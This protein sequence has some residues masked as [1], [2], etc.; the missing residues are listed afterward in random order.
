MPRPRTPARAAIVAVVVAA[1]LGGVEPDRPVGATIVTQVEPAR[2][3]TPRWVERIRELVGDRPMSVAIGDDGETWFRHRDW[4]LRAPASNEK[5]LLSMA[6]FDRFGTERTIRTSVTTAAPRRRATIHGDVY[7]VGRGDPEVADAQVRELARQVAS[8]GIRRIRGSVVG[9]LGG[10]RRDWWATG[11]RDYFPRWYIARPTALTYRGNRD[12]AGRHVPDPE[13]RAAAALTRRLRKLG[14]RVVDPAAAARPPADTRVLA[15]IASDPLAAIVRRMNVV[16][17]NFSAEVLGKV[18]AA[19]VYGRGTIA[20][21]GRAIAAFVAAHGLAFEAND[22][23]GLSYA[24]RASARGIV[25]LLWVAD[26]HDWGRTLRAG[27][28]RGGRGTLEDRLRDVRVRAKTGTLEAVSALSGWVW[29]EQE[30]TWAEF[31]ILS[32]GMSTWT[33]KSIEDRIV[34]IVA[35]TATDP[36]PDS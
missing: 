32:S 16:S 30:G 26:G 29:L 36:T 15:E 13:R 33:A 19:D 24:N 18:L 8:A 27:L 3:E 17:R 12:A 35:N 22:G 20:N 25:Q 10:L 34:R 6:L 14:V 4:V 9:S 31:S 1:I 21:A 7:L 28:A 5:L 23:S 2:R 11:W